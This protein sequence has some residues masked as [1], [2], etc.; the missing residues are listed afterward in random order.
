MSINYIYLSTVAS[1]Q[2]RSN[3][4]DIEREVCI[5]ISNKNIRISFPYK[6]LYGCVWPYVRWGKKS[7]KGIGINFIKKKKK[8]KKKEDRD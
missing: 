8:K 4:Y 2:T 5:K 1:L 7:Y 3:S 6:K